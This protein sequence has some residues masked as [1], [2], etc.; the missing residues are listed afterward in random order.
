MVLLL[1]L[2][3]LNLMEGKLTIEH[4]LLR[5]GKIFLLEKRDDHLIGI[6]SLSM[7]CQHTTI[8][9]PAACYLNRDKLFLTLSDQYHSPEQD[10][11]LG[12]KHLSLLEFETWRLDS[13][14]FTL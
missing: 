12:S 7:G 3:G 8:D 10:S 13:L 1:Y 9:H 11:N 2:S 6:Q 4:Y 14:V 5:T